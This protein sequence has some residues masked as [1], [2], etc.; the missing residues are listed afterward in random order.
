[1]HLYTAI[2][3]VQ[4]STILYCQ[5]SFLT[6]LLLCGMHGLPTQ[7]MTS[8]LAVDWLLDRVDSVCK[9][10]TDATAVGVVAHLTGGYEDRGVGDIPMVIVN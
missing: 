10:L 9:T 5:D 1:M 6:V 4:I 3:D 2:C 8:L 7:N